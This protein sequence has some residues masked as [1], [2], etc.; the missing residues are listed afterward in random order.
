[1][2]LPSISVVICTRERPR[3]LY[4]LLLTVNNQENTPLEVIIIDDSTSCKTENI[5]KESMNNLNNIGKRIRYYEG[6]EEGLAAA[7]NVGVRKS[8]GD[9]IL[10]LDDDTLAPRGLLS[11]IAQFFKGNQKAYGVQ[12]RIVYRSRKAR[13]KN[14]LLDNL[15][16]VQEKIRLNFQD[17]GLNKV[18][19]NTS[20]RLNCKAIP[21]ARLQGCC[22]CYRKEV[23]EHMKFDENLKRY[24]F[25][26]DLDFSYRLGKHADNALYVLNDAWVYHRES[27]K[28]RLGK[29]HLVFM[30]TVYSFYIFF[31]N[32]YDESLFNLCF[33]ALSQFV[34]IFFETLYLFT[35]RGIKTHVDIILLVE[36]Y[37]Y[38]FRNVRKIARGELEFFNDN[39]LKS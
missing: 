37:F 39:Y 11:R 32:F 30:R 22:H 23:F 29:K 3:D 26:E 38:S 16:K 35:K 17:Y 25:G 12:P 28:G 7:R 5:V 36:S 1:M 9:L 33:F 31:K 13:D 34:T 18:Y 27:T 10:F 24:S 6:V 15:I 21:A 4:R 19:Y 2:S 8:K 20:L 14:L